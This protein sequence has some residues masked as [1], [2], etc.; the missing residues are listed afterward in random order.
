MYRKPLNISVIRLRLPAIP[1][2]FLKADKVVL[3][4]VGAFGDCMDNLKKYGLIDAVVDFVK[5]GKPF[6]GICL[7]LQLL[8]TYSEEFGPVEGLNLVKGKVVRFPKGLK[9]P[10]MGWN[11]VEMVRENPLLKGIKDGDFFYFV[12]SYYVVP[13]NEEVVSTFTDYSIKFVS[14]INKDN[15]FACQ[16]H[17]EKS[18][19]VGLKVLDN[20]AKL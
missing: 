12:H 1:M 5:S 10:H 15:I 14:M 11:Q 7:G 9:V 3:P 13:E 17:P 4:G 18:Q 16:F 19:K 6:L 20:F 8:F 2:K